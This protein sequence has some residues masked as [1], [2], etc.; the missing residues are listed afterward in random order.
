MQENEPV[1]LV[2]SAFGREII[3]EK[4]EIIPEKGEI[5]CE[6]QH[7]VSCFPSREAHFETLFFR[8]ALTQYSRL[9]NA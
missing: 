3:P 6:K 5:L 7:S 8:R 1:L 4:G 2:F 9:L